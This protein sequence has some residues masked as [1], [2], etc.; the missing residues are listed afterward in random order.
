MTPLVPYEPNPRAGWF[1]E[2]FFQHIDV[3]AAWVERIRQ[4]ATVGPVVYILRNLSVVDFFALDYL[5]KRYDLPRIRFVND[6]GLFVFEPMRGGV[7]S[8]LRTW[9]SQPRDTERLRQVLRTRGSAALFLKRPANLLEAK[10]RGRIEGDAFL[11]TLFAVQRETLAP[12]QLCPQVFVW[13][14]GPDTGGQN[15][16]DVVFGPREWPGTLR[17]VT[18]FVMNY[19][20]C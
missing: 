15:P 20:L 19:R 16:L 5:T 13:S 10:S 14:R 4:A 8:A 6:L 3:D 18:Q 2:R 1:T 11:R 17:T 7:L 9:V 12:I